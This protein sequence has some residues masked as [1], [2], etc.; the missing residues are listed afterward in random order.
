VSKQASQPA[1][2]PWMAGQFASILSQKSVLENGIKTEGFPQTIYGPLPE[3]AYP[4]GKG[5]F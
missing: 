2:M 4:Q 1:F 5:Q 3:I